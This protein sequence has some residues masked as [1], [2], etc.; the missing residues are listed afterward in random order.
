MIFSLILTAMLQEIPSEPI[1]WRDLRAGMPKSQVKTLYPKY[2]AEVVEGCP[3]QVLSTYKK[4]NLRTVILVNTINS[5]PCSDRV[6]LYLVQAYGS[7][8]M[9]R[10]G[11]EETGTVSAGSSV[12]SFSHHRHDETWVIGP[13]R[14]LFVTFPGSHKGYNII[15]SKASEGLVSGYR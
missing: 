7:P 3:V 10:S 2:R 1:L 14:I 4:D 5:P 13:L 15:F 9:E 6:R 11:T 8:Q 12:S